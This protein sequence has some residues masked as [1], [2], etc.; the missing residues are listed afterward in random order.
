MYLEVIIHQYHIT[1][2]RRRILGIVYMCVFPYT[3]S[4]TVLILY[5]PMF[6]NPRGG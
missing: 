3:V 4:F 1:T 6:G 5:T 2:L